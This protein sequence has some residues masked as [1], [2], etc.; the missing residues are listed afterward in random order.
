MFPEVM[1]VRKS[2]SITAQQERFLKQHS[3]SLSRLTQKAIEREIDDRKFAAATK[4]ARK[5]IEAGRYTEM[6]MDE[7]LEQAKKW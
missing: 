5:E 6:D 1:A 7:F 4:A 3:I 2:I